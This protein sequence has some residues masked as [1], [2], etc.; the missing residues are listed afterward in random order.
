MRLRESLEQGTEDDRCV[1]ADVA[2]VE[3]FRQVP[4]SWPARQTRRCGVLAA[5]Q[6]RDDVFDAVAA[7]SLEEREGFRDGGNFAEAFSEDGGV[8]YQRTSRV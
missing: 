4:A 2:A 7:E 5:G 8:F 6:G 3:P 1:P